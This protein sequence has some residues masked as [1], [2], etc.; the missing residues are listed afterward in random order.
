MIPVVPA[1]GQEPA[2]PA[3]GA[4]RSKR[5]QDGVRNLSLT[6][7]RRLCVMRSRI[8]FLVG[9]LLASPASAASNR[10]DVVRCDVVRD[11]AGRVGPIVGAASS[12]RD[13]ACARLRRVVDKFQTVIRDASD[14]EIDRDYLAAAFDRRISDG[15]AALTASQTWRTALDDAGMYQPIEFE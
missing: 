6:A 2:L 7:A 14:R 10:I 9:A 13:I 1:P 12:C 11:L 3:N 8:V 15:T 5:Q 4:L